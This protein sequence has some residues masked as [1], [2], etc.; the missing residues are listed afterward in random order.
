MQRR[1][2]RRSNALHKQLTASRQ[3]LDALA[4]RE[5]KAVLWSPDEDDEQQAEHIAL[6]TLPEREPLAA[7]AVDDAVSSELPSPRS[8]Q[9]QRPTLQHMSSSLRQSI[10]ARVQGNKQQQLLLQYVLCPLTRRR[11]HCAVGSG[12]DAASTV[13]RTDD[14]QP[15]TQPVAKQVY[16][17]LVRVVNP[18]PPPSPAACL[19]VCFICRSVGLSQK[20]PMHG[21]H[22]PVPVSALPV[23]VTGYQACPWYMLKPGEAQQHS[24][25]C[26]R[27][28]AHRSRAQFE[29]MIQTL[30]Q[31]Q[32]PLPIVRN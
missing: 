12:L 20:H 26:L 8:P 2:I 4:E 7:A 3:L 6:S 10:T 13:L 30:L 9:Q 16:E 11:A 19:P 17:E 18:S 28:A 22:D 27:Q 29:S 15:H 32:L 31:L 5:D 23:Q 14:L 24:R 21:T 1:S 25:Y